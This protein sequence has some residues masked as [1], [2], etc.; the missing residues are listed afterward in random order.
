MVEDGP[1]AGAATY[2]ARA[3]PD[4]GE[5]PFEH[6]RERFPVDDG[7]VLDLGCGTGQLAV[8]LA[9]H[10]DAV[11]AM[12]PDEGML[13][14][15]RER[16]AEAGRENVETRRGSDAD[17][18][19]GAIDD[20]TPLA[21][22]TMGRSFHWMDRRPTLD[23]L[24]EHTRAGGGVAIVGDVAWITGGDEPWTRAVYDVVGEYVDDLPER[25][26]PETVEYEDPYDELL[27]EREFADVA[28]E[29]FE[30]AHRWTL[31]AIVDY[32]CS[33]SFCDPLRDP[34][35]RA[36]IERDLRDR[37]GDGPFEHANR[38][39]VTSG[40]VPHGPGG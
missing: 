19:A 11:V 26:D 36:A 34:E 8:P 35:T 33:L 4:Y 13:R 6:L 14:A 38:V 15:T 18:R 30:V 31:D 40:V 7:R 27:A 32:L 2:Y 29:T 5:R 39:R 16:A 22:T 3:R 20:R 23:W 12:D 1:F 24:R 9:A 10:A 28:D 17:L 25:Y 21:L 37:L